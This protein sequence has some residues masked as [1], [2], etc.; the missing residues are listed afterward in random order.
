MLAASL[1]PSMLQLREVPQYR[2]K[3]PPKRY[4]VHSYE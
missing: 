3:L 2:L 1:L 4:F